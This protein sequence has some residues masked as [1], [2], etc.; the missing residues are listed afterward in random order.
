MK[1]TSRT[2]KLLALFAVAAGLI[3][4]TSY[5]SKEEQ[6]GHFTRMKTLT[7][8]YEKKTSL[9][10]LYSTVN[11]V[12]AQVKNLDWSRHNAQKQEDMPVILMYIE[13]GL[14]RFLFP[15][16]VDRNVH[17]LVEK[18]EG[19]DGQLRIKP[20]GFT[21]E[22]GSLNLICTSKMQIE[23]TLVDY[24]GGDALWTARFAV[25]KEFGSKQTEEVSQKFY[26]QVVDRLIQMQV[27]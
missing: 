20:V 14:N 8:S 12:N 26:S 27:I 6:R 4:C 15:A 25:G 17:V 7:I 21:V 22:C 9:S 5:I 3:G 23:V 1:N 18:I 19:A 2:M 10:G 11:D 13:D 24:R 16:L